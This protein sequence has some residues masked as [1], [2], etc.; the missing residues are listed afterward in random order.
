MAETRAADLLDLLG[1]ADKARA[2]PGVLS[3]G[4][5]QRLAIARALANEPTLLLADEPTGA[6]DSEGGEEVIELLRRLHGGGQ[7]IVLVTHDA[8]VAAAAG[9]VVRMRDGR[10]R[11]ARAG[12][13]AGQRQG[14]RDRGTLIMSRPGRRPGRARGSAG[15][16][17]RPRPR[18]RG[19]AARGWGGPPAD[20][21]GPAGW[22]T[23]GGSRWPGCGCRCLAA[24]SAL[25]EGGGRRGARQGPGR[26]RLCPGAGTGAAVADGRPG[27]WPHA[28]ALTAGRLASQPPAGQHQ[29]AR[30]AA[31]VAAALVIAASCHF[32][33]AL[34]DGQLGGRAR[35]TGAAIAY[36]GALGTG[37]AFALA[38]RPLPWPVAALGLAAAVGCAL[39]AV[40]ARYLHAT[41]AGRE[42]LQWLAIGVVVAV[43]A[44][45]IIVVLHLLVAWPAAVAA[46]AAGV[47]V[48]IPLS[49]IAGGIPRLAPLGGRLLVHVLWV[50]GFS[51]VVA[52]VY[53]VIVL[54]LGKGPAD[55]SDRRSSAC[56]CSPRRWRRP[57]TCHPGTAAGLGHPVVYGAREA[58]D[59]VLRTFGSRMTRAVAMDE[60]LLQLAE[61]LRKTMA[62][63]GPRCTRAAG[64]VLD[65]RG[66]C[67]TRAAAR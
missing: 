56:P 37:L 48:A 13:A 45:V 25:D 27:R 51:L 38:G 33:L 9:R 6:L 66:R 57:A 36:L 8:G 21:G 65:A 62:L 24:P 54:G 32:L 64:E 52:A 2:V 59:E 30:A 28:V 40:R 46:A 20:R 11:R 58:P 10:D 3:G 14:R 42:R 7:T 55:A 23:V 12:A 17:H 18:R 53:V 43:D 19:P 15:E 35:R 31:T 49:L 60:L 44:A 34:P 1:I 39:P 63:T 47:T 41:A 5:R 16:R 50:A 29:L 22:S 26:G 61:S 4:Q 67:R